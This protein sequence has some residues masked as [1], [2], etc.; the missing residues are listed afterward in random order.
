VSKTAWAVLATV[1]MAVAAIAANPVPAAALPRHCLA[2]AP[3]ATTDYQAIADTRVAGFGVGDITSMARLPDGR[4]FIA[5]GD[6]AYFDLNPDGSPGALAGFANNTAWVQSG[7]CFTLLDRPGPGP[8][9]WVLPPQEDGSIYWPGAS[10]VVGS[11]L[12]VFMQRLRL[13]S[14]FGTSL[15]S[16]VAAFDLPSLKMAR[17]TT[18]PWTPSRV[19]GGGAVY[20][21]GYIYTYASQRRTCQFCFAGDMAFQVFM[22]TVSKSKPTRCEVSTI[23]DITS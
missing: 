13:D 15:G 11:R 17:L 18:M 10:V 23:C 22:F 8:R 5:F 12:Y 21:D 9:S 2:H 6:T 4:R 19:F 14:T 16:A 7:R 1:T 3:A 20:D